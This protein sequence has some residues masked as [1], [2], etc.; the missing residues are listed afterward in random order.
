ML[1]L[2]DGDGVLTRMKISEVTANWRLFNRETLSVAT[3][4]RLLS[5][6]GDREHNLKAKDRLEVTRI[7]EKG[8]EVKRGM[9]P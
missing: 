5:V 6:A 8:I 3:G 4:E 9:T 7:S 1:S 2:V